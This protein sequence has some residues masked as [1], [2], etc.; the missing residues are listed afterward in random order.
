MEGFSAR[1]THDQLRRRQ[2]NFDPTGHEPGRANF[3]RDKITTLSALNKMALFMIKIANKLMKAKIAVVFV[4]YGTGAMN[5]ITRRDGCLFNRIPPSIFTPDVEAFK[6]FQQ[7]FELPKLLRK[8]N[9][10]TYMDALDE[11]AAI[12]C[13]TFTKQNGKVAV[14]RPSAMFKEE[15][16]RAKFT[17]YQQE[18][19][20]CFSEQVDINSSWGDLIVITPDQ[21]LPVQNYIVPMDGSNH[22]TSHFTHIGN[23]ISHSF[24][25]NI[26]DKVKF[27]NANYCVPIFIQALIQLN[28]INFS[29]YIT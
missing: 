14:K 27:R 1:N 5:S 6:P 7:V 28:S 22:M 16:T 8:S 23:L 4:S 11:N 3:V 17:R 2:R 13:L 19:Y 12:I 25:R 18:R 9:H 15:T 24:K 10:P 21:E 26:F 29:K 20:E